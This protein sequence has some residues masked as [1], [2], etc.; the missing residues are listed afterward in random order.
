MVGDYH[1]NKI[2]SKDIKRLF[3]NFE[4][5]VCYYN[6]DAGWLRIVLFFTFIFLENAFS[7]YA[8]FHAPLDE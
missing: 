4:A 1:V 5:W 3:E 8:I 2:T 6:C 7:N